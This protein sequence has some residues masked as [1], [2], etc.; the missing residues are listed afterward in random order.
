MNGGRL[1]RA[2]PDPAA[3]RDIVANG[4]G[5]MPAFSGRLSAEELD[6]VV[7]Y[8]REIINDVSG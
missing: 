6:A 2:H 8:T 7:R 3:Q 5:T 4:R 1:E